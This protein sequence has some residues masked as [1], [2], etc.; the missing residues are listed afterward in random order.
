[1]IDIT[2]ESAERREQ[3]IIGA[4]VLALAAL[5]TV[6]CHQLCTRMI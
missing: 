6:W 5:A 2:A 3:F 4:N 1:M